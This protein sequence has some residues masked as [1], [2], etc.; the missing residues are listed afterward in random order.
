MEK[1][2]GEIKNVC[3]GYKD[4]PA[5]V[6]EEVVMKGMIHRIHERFFRVSHG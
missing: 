2:D 5:H 6:G 1:I 3:V 4:F